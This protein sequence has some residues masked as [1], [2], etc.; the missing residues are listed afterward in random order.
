MVG[1]IVFEPAAGDITG[2]AVS[3]Y[4]RRRGI[5]SVL[6]AEMLRLN[7]AQGVKCI[8]TE[9]GRDASIAGFLAAKNIPLAGMQFEMVKKL[10]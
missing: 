7:R 3:P 2:I 1:Y 8:N 10:R 4:L 5:G 9:R 6:L